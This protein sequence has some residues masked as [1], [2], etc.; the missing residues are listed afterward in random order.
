MVAAA[1]QHVAN[2]YELTVDNLETAQDHNCSMG[3]YAP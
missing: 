2:S 1:V 3:W